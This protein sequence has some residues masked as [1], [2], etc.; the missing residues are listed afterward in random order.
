[1]SGRASGFVKDF[2][3]KNNNFPPDQPCNKVEI[4]VEE[5]EEEEEEEEQEEQE[6][7]EEEQQQEQEEQS[8]IAEIQ[9]QILSAPQR[10]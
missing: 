5:E 2:G 7:E 10:T 6:E 8:H 9:L 1:M 4:I 3:K